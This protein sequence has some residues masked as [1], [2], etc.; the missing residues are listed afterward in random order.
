MS[1]AALLQDY[2]YAAVFV[3]AFLEG[4]TFLIMAGFAAHRGYLD[5]P[6]VMG[7]AAVGGFLGDQMYFYLGRRYGL[8][9]L[10][11]FPALKPRAAQAQAL[12]S[13]YHLPL[14]LGIRFLYGL[15]TVGPLA[16][17]M[18]PVGWIRFF[19]LN[20]IG[21]V[22]WAVLVGGAGYLFGQ[23]MALVFD[24]LRRYE[25]ALLALMALAGIVV[26]LYYRWRQRCASRSSP[27]SG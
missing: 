20:F 10:N 2:G 8:R 16:I 9:I 19:A 21:A 18:S 4:E 26:W 3:G 22:A 15:R 27:P 17:G 5:L 23:A 24:D 25:E 7:M 14:I 12:L 1:L 13:R 11:R 6:W